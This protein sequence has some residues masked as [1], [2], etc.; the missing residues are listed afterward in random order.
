MEFAEDDSETI[1]VVLKG[2]TGGYLPIS[3]FARLYEELDDA[4]DHLS[5]I[6]ARMRFM[7]IV[8]FVTGVVAGASSVLA[9]SVWN[10]L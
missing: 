7:R 10:V 4:R 2:R 5:C 3:E 6:L 9:A 8:W 1:V